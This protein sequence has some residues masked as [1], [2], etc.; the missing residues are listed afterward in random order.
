MTAERKPTKEVDLKAHAQLVDQPDGTYVLRLPWLGLAVSGETP[1]DA[2]RALSTMLVHELEASPEF[3]E[4]FGD[5]V[6][7]NAAPVAPV[8]T[9]DI[10]AHEAQR[11]IPALTTE[12][13]DQATW[14]DER[15]LVVDFWAPW[16]TPCI[17]FAPA[18]REASVRLGSGV[19]LASVDID[20]NPEL[21]ERFSVRTLPT[22]V[23]LDHGEEIQRLIGSRSLAQLMDELGD[24]AG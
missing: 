13:F 3:R 23:V 7:R 15:P 9:L 18:L 24:L 16:C 11:E 12:T 5:F 4:R 20:E 2:W 1:E 14:V 19:R 6:A 21:A 10:S 22:V 17:N 8:T